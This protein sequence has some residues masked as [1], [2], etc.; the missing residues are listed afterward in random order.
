[1]DAI[2][3]LADLGASVHTPA[4]DGC[5]P[6]CIA[7]DEG[8]VDAINA[9][10][11]LG[12]SVNTP[13]NDGGTPVFIAAQNGHVDAI[14]TLAALGAS[15]NTPEN[16]GGTPVFIAA[17]RGHVDAIKTW[18]ALLLYKLGADL[19][20][21]AFFSGEKWSVLDVAE[22]ADQQAAVELIKSILRKIESECECCGSSTQTV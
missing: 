1:M 2:K 10:A 18:A 16:D 22:A 3:A 13:A 4:H 17:L 12:A 5:T 15:V 19:G 20:C 9:L 8:H 7:A 21:C 14:K 11:A 6:V